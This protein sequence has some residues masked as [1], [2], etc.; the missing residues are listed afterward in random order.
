[1]C[2]RATVRLFRVRDTDSDSWALR[3]RRTAE[4]NKSMFLCVCAP[5]GRGTIQLV[6]HA[7]SPVKAL[8]CS[9]RG[10]AK[11]IMSWPLYNY[12]CASVFVYNRG[13]AEIR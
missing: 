9:D 6:K 8:C 7:P 13:K 12:E 3:E 11:S 4:Q 5:R 2:E 1:M 10:K